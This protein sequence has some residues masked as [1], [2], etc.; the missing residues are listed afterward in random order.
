MAHVREHILGTPGVTGMHDLHVWTITSGMNVISA[1]VVLGH[2]AQGAEVL[3]ELSRCLA[4]DFDIE[5]STFQLEG[6]D[7]LHAEA[8]LHA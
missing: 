4:D 1:H 3:Q 7:H 2:D 8:V 6:P 5:H